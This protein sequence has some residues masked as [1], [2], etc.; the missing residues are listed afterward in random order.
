MIRWLVDYFSALLDVWL[1]LVL[2][3]NTQKI[4]LSKCTQIRTCMYMIP[5]S[6]SHLQTHNTN[7]CIIGP[8]GVMWAA[9][10][11]KQRRGRQ[12]VWRSYAELGE[13]CLGMELVLVSL[14]LFFTW[15]YEVSVMH[16]TRYAVY[17]ASPGHL[18]LSIFQLLM[19]VKLIFEAWPNYHD[20]F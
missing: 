5:T 16:S 13:C 19:L 3:Q 7:T 2:A 18:H 17:S 20:H 4:T 1:K 14:C 10:I 12:G 8:L 9:A 11:K 15:L 6:P